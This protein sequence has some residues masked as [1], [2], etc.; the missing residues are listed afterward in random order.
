[1]GF[2]LHEGESLASEASWREAIDVLASGGALVVFA[3]RSAAAQTASG[4]AAATASVLVWRTEAQHVGRRV[5]VRP[6]HLYLPESVAQ[7]R[8]ILVYVDSALAHPEGVPAAPQRDDEAQT[9]AA[10]IESQFRENAFQ[11]RPRDLECFLA[12]LEE[13]LRLDLREDWASRPDWKQDAE[14]FV[15]S[16]VAAGWVKRTNYLNPGHVVR[17]R[18]TLDDYRHLQQQCALR[19]LEVEEAGSLPRS[20]W[21]R[22]IVWLETLIGLPIALYGLL[23]HLAIGLVCLL[24]G[25]SKKEH[26]RPRTTEWAIRCVVALAFYITQVFLVAHWWGRAAAGYYAPTLPVSGAY[27]W[28][29]RWVLRR[30]A[31]PVFISLTIPA[32][33]RKMK[34]L[35]QVP[36]KELDEQVTSDK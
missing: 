3:D 22:A 17:L 19:R 21:Q 29:Y 2:I 9:L 36:V 1:M 30:Q 13:V 6:V 32:L 31:R 5:E 28:R 25:S 11:L 24:I 15:L 23:N 4:A 12:D 26:P 35:R 33:T 20:R 14:G 7:S 18:Q 16:G 27:L 8:E 10:A 34:R